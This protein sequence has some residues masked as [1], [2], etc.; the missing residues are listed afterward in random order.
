MGKESFLLYK[1]F[2]EPIKDLPDEE[3]GQL[4]RLI[5]IHQINHGSIGSTTVNPKIKMAFEFFKNQFRLDDEKYQ[6]FVALQ[7]EK[8]R[9][10]AEAR[11]SKKSTKPTAVNRGQPV[12]TES[13]YN[14]NENENEN[15]KEIIYTKK[16]FKTNWKEIL[17]KV[18]VEFLNKP[19]YKEKDFDKV[20]EEFLDGI[21][22]KN[23]GYKDY[24]LAYLKWVRNSRHQNGGV[25]PNGTLLP[26]KQS[27]EELGKIKKTFLNN[28]DFNY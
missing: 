3:L 16:Y 9:K 12:S 21:E 28:Q 20:M 1:S 4:L 23:Y 25:R 13:T 14:E 27:L 24:Y 8:G 10:S 5:F 22:M 15:E 18:K 7:K 17:E 6:K 2:Y 11:K 19:E 26:D